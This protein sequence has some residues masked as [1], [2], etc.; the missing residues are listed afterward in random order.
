MIITDLLIIGGCYLAGF[1]S[2]AMVVT[3]IVRVRT[4]TYFQSKGC[5]PRVAEH[6]ATR[7]IREGR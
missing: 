6:F 7:L 4:E 1:I 3:R 5:S 2:G